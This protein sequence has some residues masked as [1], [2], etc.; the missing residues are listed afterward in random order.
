ACS[1]IGFPI[2]GLGTLVDDRGMIALAESGAGGRVE[3]A[4][5][6]TPL[7][8]SVEAPAPNLIVHFGERGSDG[9]LPLIIQA[10]QEGGRDD[11]PTAILAIMPAGELSN[12]QYVEGVTYAEDHDG[13]WERRFGLDISR[14]PFTAIVSPDGKVAWQHEGE[15]EAATLAGALKKYLVTAKPIA[16]T[17]PPRALRLGIAPP[18]F[19][20][21]Y[22]PGSEVTLRKVAGRPAVIVFWRSRSAQSIDLIHELTRA[23][24]TRNGKSPLILAVNDGEPAEVARQ[25]ARENKL[26]ARL[27]TDPDRNI[28]SAYGVNTWPTTVEVDASGVTRTVRFGRLA[29][30]GSNAGATVM[31]GK[32]DYARN[33]Q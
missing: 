30:E 32:A 15:V 29:A 19:L 2:G 4:G 24:D 14:R 23:S 3:I 6:T 16:P 22:A 7:A 10:L 27:V 8:A 25:A 28:S 13:E 21:E 9:G 12:T 11:A 18:N 17:L 5:H 31:Q 1:L 20:F 33:G 26:T